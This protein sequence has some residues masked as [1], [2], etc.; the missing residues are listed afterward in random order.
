LIGAFWDFTSDLTIKDTA[1]TTLPLAAHTDTTYFTDPSGLQLFHLLS[2]TGGSGGASLLVDGFH[3]AQILRSESPESYDTLSRYQIPWHASGNE[4]ISIK[5]VMT[6]PVLEHWRRSG[7]SEPELVRVRWNNDDRGAKDDWESV[8]ACRGWYVAAKK[9]AG[10]LKRSKLE[11]WEQL[12]P[13]RPLSEF[14][15]T[16]LFSSV[17]SWIFGV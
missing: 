5:P 4:A 2:H 6:F 8:D 13:G 12:K 11:I 7:K 9:W 16:F 10:I 15:P 17:L 3:A 1:Y 14:F